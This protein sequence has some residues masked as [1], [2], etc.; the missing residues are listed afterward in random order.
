MSKA[1]LRESDLPDTPDLPPLVSPLPPGAKNY[2]TP[3]GKRRLE[4]ELTHLVDVQR[5][6]LLTLDPQSDA[7]RELHLFDQRIRYLQQSLRTAE[8][9]PP[10]PPPHDV[11]RFGAAVHVRD[12][13]NDESTYRI[14]GVD[15]TNLDRGWISYFSPLARALLNARIGDQVR[16]RSPS[17]EKALVIV[18]IDYE[19]VSLR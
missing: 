2:L 14:V 17:G 6:P 13:N 11:V 19:P 5:P 4:A 10:P 9:V 15:E 18:G 7:R 1:F 16:F 12:E 3:D 8:V